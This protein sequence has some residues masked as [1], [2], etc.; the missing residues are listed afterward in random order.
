M[1]SDQIMADVRQRAE[2]ERLR[3]WVISTR[4]QLRSKGLNPK[5]RARLKAELPA[6]RAECKRRGI[7]DFKRPYRG[8]NDHIL[9][10]T[11][12]RLPSGAVR[13]DSYEPKPSQPPHQR[14][15]QPEPRPSPADGNTLLAELEASVAELARK[16]QH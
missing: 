11:A 10:V 2:D 1:L 7:T 15:P 12:E 13:V 6:A 3:H 5:L 14:K 8:E 16:P 9:I 4:R